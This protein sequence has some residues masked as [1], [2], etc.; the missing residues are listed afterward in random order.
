MNEEMKKSLADGTVFKIAGSYVFALNIPD[1]DIGMAGSRCSHCET[2]GAYALHLCR[3]CGLPLAGPYGLPQWSDW[4]HTNQKKREDYARYTFDNESH[5]RIKYHN[6]AHVP[7]SSHEA[8][9][10]QDMTHTEERL[11][12][13]AHGKSLS[14]FM[15]SIIAD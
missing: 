7:L 4:T 10:L 9:H 14:E 12:K 13:I 15:D 1:D 8:Q 3:G 6:V 5:G 11:F 2:A